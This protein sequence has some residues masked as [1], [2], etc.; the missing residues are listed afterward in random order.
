MV[1]AWLPTHK[2]ILGICRGLQQINVVCGG[3]LVQDIPTQVGARVIHRKPK[4]SGRATHMVN[5]EPGTKLQ[6]LLPG[7]A[8]QVN[9]NHHQ[10]AKDVGRDLKV[11]AR[12]ADGVIEA[13]EFT[14]GRWGMLVQWHPETIKDAQHRKAIYGAFVRACGEATR[15]VLTPAR[16]ARKAGMKRKSLR[17]QKRCDYAG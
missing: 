15:R 12:S 8:V 9:S 13:L 7:E 14:D 2:P 6:S 4:G 10:A 3:T 5:I 1:E 16:A 17:Y 11:S